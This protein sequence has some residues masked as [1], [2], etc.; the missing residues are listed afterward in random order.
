M[1]P[2]LISAA[3]STIVCLVIIPILIPFLKRLKFGQ[4]IREEGPSW[5]Q[6]KSGT[7]TM[8]GIGFIIASALAAILVMLI[9]YKKISYDLLIPVL[10]AVAYGLVG[11]IDD[12]IKVV[13]KQN[14]GLSAKQK[15]L[16]QMLVAIL[17]TIS[18]VYL[19]FI[20]NTLIVPFMAKPLDI[21]FFM[22]PLTI[23]VQL[24]VVNSVNLTDGL[25]GLAT[26]V[27][28]I[29]SLFFLLFSLLFDNII[30]IFIAAVAGGCLAFLFF[31]AHPAKVFMGDTGSLFL[32]GAIAV[33]ATMLK[34]PLIL[35][36]VGGVYLIETLSV[37]LQVTSF[38]L[39]GKRIFKMSP[40]HHHF[41]MCGLN[42]TKIVLLFSTATLILCII[43]YFACNAFIMSIGG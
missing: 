19:G 22:I 14:L 36:I 1:N 4:S 2:V 37:I 6:K 42:E 26:S 11:F 27:T 33:T 15:F 23:L 20:D 39:T 41:E 18:M 13:K 5:H 12:F 21:G 25:D 43:G 8:G 17:S 3:I 10:T 32:G 16:A 34:M 38:K 31:N 7:P 29:V 30:G 28:L 9:M 40:I 35:I 24:S